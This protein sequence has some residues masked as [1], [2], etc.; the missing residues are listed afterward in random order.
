M[1]P[2]VII[3]YVVDNFYVLSY[4][5]IVMYNI[6]QESPIRD[7]SHNYGYKNKV[8]ILDEITVENTSHLLGDIVEMIEFEKEHSRKIEWFIN[9]PGGEVAACKS[10]ISLMALANINNVINYT[11]VIGEAGSSAS[12]IAIHG[13]K[14]FIMNYAN[15]YIH[16][17]MSGS[18][19]THP[20]ESTR[21]YK[22]EQLFFKWVYNT[23]KEKTSIPEDKLKNL[24]E[25][26]GG[27]IYAKECIKYKL[28]DTIIQN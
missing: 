8:F 18:S 6:Q 19:N 26:E 14:R 2:F 20:T 11:Y 25:H 22:N 15:H 23:Y 4:Y 10:I 27:F 3:I 17:G 5:N 7:I 21:N 16:Y 24:M 9:S 1:Y 28:A 13:N 12:I